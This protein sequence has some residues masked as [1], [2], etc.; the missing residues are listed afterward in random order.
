[1]VRDEKPIP[2]RKKREQKKGAWKAWAAKGE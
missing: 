1:M 2:G